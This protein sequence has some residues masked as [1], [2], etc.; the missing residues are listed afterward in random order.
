MDVDPAAL[1]RDISQF[2]ALLALAVQHT[3]DD[4]WLLA[5][6]REQIA[7]RTRDLREAEARDRLH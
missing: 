1:R 6:L 5:L 4:T 7:W 3:P 2:A